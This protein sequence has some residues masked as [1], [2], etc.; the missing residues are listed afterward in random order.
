MRSS[1][2]GRP[3][4][5]GRS[6]TRSI[7]PPRS[8]IPPPRTAG[9][10][11]ALACW[12]GPAF[13]EFGGLPWADLEASRLDEL[14]LMATERQAAVALRLGWAAQTVASLDRLTAGQPLREEAWRLLALALYQAGRQGDALA[15]L[16]RARARL[17]ADLGVDPGPA[18]RELEQDILAQAPH[19]SAPPPVLPASGGPAAAP[20][21][22]VLVPAVPAPAGGDLALAARPWPWRRPPRRRIWG[23]TRSWTRWSGARG[24]QRPAGWASCW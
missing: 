1:S 14:R 11:A 5:P 15:A 24:R 19:L 8:A 23:G 16:R 6:R 17:A 7:T 13:Q 21:P 4:T 22:A 18:L 10:T 20:G 9:C 2:A 12:R 3:L